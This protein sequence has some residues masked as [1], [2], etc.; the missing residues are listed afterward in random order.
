MYQLVPKKKNLFLK[1]LGFIV[2]LAVIKELFVFLFAPAPISQ[3]LDDFAS[4]INKRCPMVLD[5]TTTLNNCLA[6]TGDKLYFN[7][8]FNAVNK[9]E[10]DATFLQA[11]NK[12]TIINKIKTDPSFAFI[13]NNNISISAS[14]YDK[15]GNFICKVSVLPKDIQESKH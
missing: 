7:Y 12:E 4:S 10:V 5:S 11:T 15:A 6:V 2:A 1:I 14:Y 3:Q 8:Q 13:K 9:D